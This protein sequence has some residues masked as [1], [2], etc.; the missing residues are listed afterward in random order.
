VLNSNTGIPP[1]FFPVTA[2]GAGGQGA[3]R[4]R[5]NG[6]RGIAPMGKLADL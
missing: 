6:Y 4:D 3:Y 5:T 1:A 2:I